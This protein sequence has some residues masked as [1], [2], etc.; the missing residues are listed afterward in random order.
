MTNDDFRVM[1]SISSITKKIEDSLKRNEPKRY[2]D[3]LESEREFEQNCIQ[4]N[5]IYSPQ[6][7]IDLCK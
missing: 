6:N 4:N 7:F 3:W 1:R 5:I 2:R